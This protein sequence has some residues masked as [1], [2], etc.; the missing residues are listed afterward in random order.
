MVHMLES[1]QPGISKHG[2]GAHVLKPRLHVIVVKDSVGVVPVFEV[3]LQSSVW[4]SSIL[5]CVYQNHGLQGN[6]ELPL[7]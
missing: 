4:H 7:I 3:S 1:N 6:G 2:G 5:L